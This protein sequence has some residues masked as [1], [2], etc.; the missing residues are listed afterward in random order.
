MP[1]SCLSIKPQFYTTLFNILVA[2]ILENA[3]LTDPVFND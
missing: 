3:D 2:Y 1:E